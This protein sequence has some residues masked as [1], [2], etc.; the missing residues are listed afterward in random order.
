MTN[1]IYKFRAWDEVEK[2]MISPETIQSQDWNVLQNFQRQTGNWKPMQFTGLL[3][4]SGKEIY[5]GDILNNGD[6]DGNW[7]VTWNNTT[8]I[9]NLCETKGDICESKPMTAQYL[10]I[11][12]NIYENPELLSTNE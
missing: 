3:D 8:A 10:Q 4:K 11:I 2:R 5:E 7:T 1:R 6:R 9:Y 12:G